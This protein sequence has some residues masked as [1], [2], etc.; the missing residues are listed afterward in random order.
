MLLADKASVP[1]RSSNAKLGRAYLTSCPSKD[2]LPHELQYTPLK[3]KLIWGARLIVFGPVDQ[4]DLHVLRNVANYSSNHIQSRTPG[5]LNL[6]QQRRMETHVSHFKRGAQFWLTHVSHF[7]RSAQLWLTHV[8]HFKRSA[9]FWLSHVSHFKRSTQFWLTHVSHFKRSAQFWFPIQ[10]QKQCLK[11]K[12]LLY[13]HVP[14][15]D[16][17]V[18]DG[19]HIRRW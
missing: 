10:I 19:L 9:Q 15:N 11:S 12:F 8:S 3:I 17:S 14:H 16:V 1:T 18:N 4:K 7:K 5:D 2:S 13:C 6:Q